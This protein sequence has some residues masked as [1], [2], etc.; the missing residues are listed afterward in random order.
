MHTEMIQGHVDPLSPPAFICG[1]VKWLAVLPLPAEL[2]ALLKRLNHHYFVVTP[3]F[4]FYQVFL[5]FQIDNHRHRITGQVFVKQ[6]FYGTGTFITFQ[7]SKF[8]NGFTT[9][10][11]CLKQ[12]SG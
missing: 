10:Q 11:A 12:I 3:Q 7:L 1:F 8:R 2:L 6:N 5:S 9:S 4:K